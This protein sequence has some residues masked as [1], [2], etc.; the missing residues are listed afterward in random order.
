MFDTSIMVLFVQ[1][2]QPVA[3]NGF[4]KVRW[5]VASF[6]GNLLEQGPRGSE[7]Q[8]GVEI[9]PWEDQLNA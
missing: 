4:S 1:N 3:T 8:L 9:H 6:F 5:S 7:A 2:D